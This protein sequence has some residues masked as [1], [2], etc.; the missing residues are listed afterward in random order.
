MIADP[1]RI[2]WLLEQRGRMSLELTREEGLKDLR[3]AARLIPSDPPTADR[4]RVLAALAK[5]LYFSRRMVEA[6]E[7]SAEALRVAR[8]VD[9]PLAEGSTA[10]TMICIDAGTRDFDVRLADLQRIEQMTRPSAN[11]QM[12]LRL[13]I[14]FSD[15]LEGMG[16]HER[17]A[18]VAR[19]GIADAR[20]HGVERITGTFLAA[21]LA[22]PLVSLGRWDEALSVLE[23]ALQQEPPLVSR[24]YLHVMVGEVKLAR[25]DLGGA[26]AEAFAAREIVGSHG[27]KGAQDLFAVVRLEAAMRLAEGDL[28]ELL[29]VIEPA[30]HAFDMPDDPRYA[31]PVLVY[32]A[33][34]CADGLQRTP[35][36]THARAFGRARMRGATR[37]PGE[38]GPARR[39]AVGDGRIAALL[40]AAFGAIE[41]RAD[42]L[43]VHGPVQEAHRLTFLAESS[44]V[45]GQHDCDAWDA[46]AA[47]WQRIGQPYPEARARWRAAEARIR[48]G[49]RQ[50]AADR[51]RRAAELAEG[52]RAAPLRDAVA[53]LA[54]R[55]R[56]DSGDPADR[57]VVAALTPREWEV[58]R[59]VADGR[60][61][62]EIATAL[63]ISAKT[64]SVHVSNILAKLGVGGRGEAA[65]AAHRMGLFETASEHAQSTQ[66]G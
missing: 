62:R 38:H 66:V 22:E 37:G 46:A 33:A 16:A 32:G 13:A 55:G 29:T 12:A 26:A 4:A 21:N 25:G 35:A 1:A 54:R 8:Q 41:D 65:A 24:S 20:R 5:E 42:K 64:A 7:V 3:T 57:A 6:R 63:F 48:A 11:Y 15:T 44:R 28:D 31:W 47:A 14:N 39:G 50:G 23:H 53:D 2:A 45:R 27:F 49:D 40:E 51:L 10:L 61:N 59:L 36:V 56:I 9:D 60:S 58:L 19:R 34:G 52:L 30:L 18:E 17:A 43:T